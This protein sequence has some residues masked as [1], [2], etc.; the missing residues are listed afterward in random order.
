M[1][2]GFE[3]LPAADADFPALWSIFDEVVRSGETYAYG[4]EADEAW[5]RDYWMGAGAKAYVAKR[6]G[7]VLGACAIRPAWT[8]RAAHIANASFIVGAQARGQG[9]GRALGEFALAEAKRQGYAAMLFRFVVSTNEV[10]VKLWKSL[11]FSIIGVIPQGYRHAKLGLVDV[12]IM[13][14]AL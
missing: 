6:G 2:R 13:H 1:T 8:G 12:Y 5:A 11:G 3:I 10:A 7:Q 4:D 14:R 9:V